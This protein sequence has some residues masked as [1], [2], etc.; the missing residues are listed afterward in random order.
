MLTVSP[1]RRINLRR[2]VVKGLE[3]DIP[4]ARDDPD[5]EP[6]ARLDSL[7]TIWSWLFE[8]SARPM[9]APQPTS[10]KTLTFLCGDVSPQ[11]LH[12][13]PK[14]P[15]ALQNFTLKGSPWTTHPDY[16]PTNRSLILNALRPHAHSLLTLTPD[17]Y[18]HT[19]CPPVDFHPFKRL[20]QLT[21]DPK[22]LRCDSAEKHHRLD[23]HLPPSL[24][25]LRFHEYREWGAPDLRTLALILDWVVDVSCRI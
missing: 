4:R 11:T 15:K 24:R 16:F 19:T 7:S 3:N 2:L 10:L 12:E 14:L 22:V 6:W 17:F 25:P 5:Y 1:L 18:L 13:I 21:I 20:Q 8:Q 9:S 23:C